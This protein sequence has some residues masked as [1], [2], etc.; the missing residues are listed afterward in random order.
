M[1]FGVVILFY[2]LLAIFAHFNSLKPRLNASFM[3]GLWA[4]D[5][6]HIGTCFCIAVEHRK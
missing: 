2:N 5:F 6:S 3:Q 4:I 1:Y